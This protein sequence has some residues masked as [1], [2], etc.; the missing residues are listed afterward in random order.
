MGLMFETNE[1]VVVPDGADRRWRLSPASQ[2]R[3]LCRTYWLSGRV[4]SRW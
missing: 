1:R 2:R 3:C 4:D